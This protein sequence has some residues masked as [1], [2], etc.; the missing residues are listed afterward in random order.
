MHCFKVTTLFTVISIPILF[1]LLEDQRHACGVNKP[2][3]PRLHRSNHLMLVL[4]TAG[5]SQ[6][7]YTVESFENEPHCHCILLVQKTPFS[8]GKPSLRKTLTFETLRKELISIIKKK[9]NVSRDSPGNFCTL[10][11][12]LHFSI[13][14]T[15]I[16]MS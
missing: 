4:W 13:I 16:R 7:S 2:Y 15:H 12:K 9:N 3:V 1:M 14:V 6:Y 10:I 5:V 8:H 11:F